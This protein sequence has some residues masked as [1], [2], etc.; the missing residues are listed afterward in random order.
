MSGLVGCWAPW[1]VCLAME[2]A[3]AKAVLQ[4]VLSNDMERLAPGRLVYAALLTPQ[5]KFLYDVFVGV[6]AGGRLLLDVAAESAGAFAKRLSIYCLRRDARVIG[7][8]GLA[9][10]LVWGAG[11]PEAGAPD[12][13]DP[14]LGWRVYAAEGTGH[15]AGAAPGS[16]AEYD[17][18]RVARGVPES[19]VELV[20]EET[21]IL[22]AGFERL[23]GVDFR[24]GCYVGQEVTARMKHKADLRR[25]LV[26]VAVE[27]A[28]PPGT[29][30]L[31]GDG[32]LAGTLYT[33]AAG[34]GL[35]HLRLDRAAG[36]MEAGPAR[37]RLL[38]G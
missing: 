2:G 27:G 21:Y 36:A 30:V 10:G 20:S 1:R 17:A 38:E 32:K 26:R 25:R 34:E 4:G 11:T 23:N 9:I 24:K 15:V 7:E 5:G 29:P 37:V 19:G 6:E 16:R 18:L 14:A 22:E 33:Q 31:G 35:A 8:S 28:A 3:D 12:P 13:R